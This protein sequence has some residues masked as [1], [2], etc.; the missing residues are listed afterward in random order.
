[1]QGATPPNQVP[2]LYVSPG[3][4]N[5]LSASALPLN[6]WSHLAATYDGAVARLFVNGTEVASR[7]QTG[8]MTVSADPLTIGGNTYSGQNWSGLID[9][10]RIYNR[11]LSSTE[12]QT[13][14][15]TPITVRVPT[16]PLNIRIEGP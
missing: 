4:G 7:P 6:A 2:S 14:M 1:L 8:S 3:S 16:P 10:V 9:E 11:A 5:L 13:D 15:T 12:I